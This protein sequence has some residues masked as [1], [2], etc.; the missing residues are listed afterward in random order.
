MK[1]NL[2]KISLSEEWAELSK[3]FCDPEFIHYLAKF[4]KNQ[5]VSNIL[6]CAC[7]DGHV[8]FGLAKE[9]ISGVGID[10]DK[11]LIRRAKKINSSKHIKY[12]NTSILSLS[13]DSAT[14]TK[15]FDAVMCRGNSITALNSW[16]STPKTFSPKKCQQA[17]KIGLKQMWD[18]V[19]LGGILYLDTTKQ[20]DI[21]RG[22]YEI[23][24]KNDNLK[25]KGFIKID[26][27]YKRRDVFGYG[28]VN[29]K[30]FDG[31]SSSYL[32]SPEELRRLIIKLLKPKKIWT[33]K[34]IQDK[35]YE[36]ICVKK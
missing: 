23:L 7:G 36:I 25:I 19:K 6:E 34:E 16:G 4:L 2:H 3:S 32:I 14:S 8:L 35:N 17:I 31:G 28:I 26:K 13:D 21:D 22:N 33:P 24:I 10:T 27:K 1:K 11:L 9:G 29:G 18:R 15:Y 20:K 30:Q 5:K 12:K